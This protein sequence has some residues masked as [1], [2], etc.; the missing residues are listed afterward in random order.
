MNRYLSLDHIYTKL[1]LD[2]IFQVQNCL[3]GYSIKDASVVWWGQKLQVSIPTHLKHKHIQNS[4]LLDVIVEQPE[5]II[6]SIVFSI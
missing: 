5:H 1:L 4:H 6:K 3:S 2:I